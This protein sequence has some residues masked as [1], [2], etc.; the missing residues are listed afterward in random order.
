M[1]MV[2]LSDSAMPEGTRCAVTGKGPRGINIT[3]Q[4]EGQV[5]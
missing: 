1:G 4:Q 3:G 2:F 5:A